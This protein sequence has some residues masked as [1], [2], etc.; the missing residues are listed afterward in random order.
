MRRMRRRRRRRRRRRGRRHR[1]RLSF[2][3]LRVFSTSY[4]SV[5]GFLPNYATLFTTRS[6]NPR[7]VHSLTFSFNLPVSPPPVLSYIA[8]YVSSRLGSL[9]GLAPFSPCLNV[10]L[11]SVVLGS[12]V[13]SAAGVVRN[14]VWS[15]HRVSVPLYRYD[16]RKSCKVP[17]CVVEATAV[18][19]S[20]FR[21]GQM[22]IYQ[23]GSSL[24]TRNM[25]CRARSGRSQNHSRSA[26]RKENG[27][28]TLWT[29][30]IL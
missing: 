19:Q 12:V 7:H 18:V 11:S 14:P 20:L 22:A 9:R 17:E 1:L 28:W 16:R 26:R 5:A 25:T 27:R 24:E 2:R 29:I 21:N 30:C 3:E 4:P 13:L 10:V 6:G 15:C 8:M 23:L